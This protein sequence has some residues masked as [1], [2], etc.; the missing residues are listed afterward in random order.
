MLRPRPSPRPRPIVPAYTYVLAGTGTGTSQ[1][2]RTAPRECNMY[3]NSTTLRRVLTRTTRS[4][5]VHL[6]IEPASGGDRLSMSFL[7][8]HA[9]THTTLGGGLISSY[10]NQSETS[11]Y[12]TI[13]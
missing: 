2:L 3:I 10:T 7:D 1:T 12:S 13:S 6:I 9:H 8:T 11:R 5:T 4:T